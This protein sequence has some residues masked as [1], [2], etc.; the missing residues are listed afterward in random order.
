MRTTPRPRARL[1]LA[2]LLSL[3]AVALGSAL[4]AS[5][6]APEKGYAIATESPGATREAARVLDAGGNAFDAI[7]CAAL[8][9]GF[10][11]PASSGL[12]G[13]GFAMVYSA[14][15]QRPI[16]LDFREVAPAGLDEAA[17]AERPVPADQRGHTVG[18]P[19]E[20]SGLFELHQRYG[21]LRWKDVVGRAA[22]LA[23]QGFVLEPFT[24]QQVAEQQ[25]GPI[26]R[27]A[28]FR[29]AY[30]PQGAP[31]PA[32]TKLRATKLAATLRHL[33][34]QGKRGFYEGRV[35]R[36]MVDAVAAAGG[37]L[38]LTDLAAYRT[39]QRE[40]LRVSWEGK[41]L[42]TMPAP[43]AGGLLLAQTL[44]LF[45]KAE[46]AELAATPGKRLHLLAEA[47]RG[48]F[49]DRIRHLGDPAFTPVD[50]GKLLSA[51]R[52]QRRKAGLS[53]E[54]T[55]TQPRYG[56]E[57]QGTHQLV[58]ADAEGNWV[59]LTT[60][61]N[62]PFGAK[63]VAE[64]SG[65]ILNN[66]LEDF[67][68]AKSAAVFGI[69]D[70]PNR[71]RRGARPVS[72]MAPTLVLEDGVPTLALGGSGG[73]TIGPNVTQVALRILAEGASVEAAVAA[74]RFS[75]PPP[76]SGYTLSLEQALGE[77]Y[78]A[79]LRG[80]GELISTRDWKNAVQAVSRQGGTF[81]AAADPRKHGS[82][83]ARNS[84]AQ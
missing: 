69:T 76:Q 47:M 35:A 46:L 75:I 38:A 54:R 51:P 77:R 62:A 3:V 42:A 64:Q 27:S 39:V 65:I 58:A 9:S 8:V 14:R 11:N 24:S 32:G 70:N 31:A 25:N 57:E 6:A 26:A 2:L 21:K 84:A 50:M 40:P 23:A 10:T 1:E 49:A 44:A 30:L 17:L 71:P 43:S 29:G 12:G 37:A 83:L 78:E 82:A 55:H 66:E 79:D 81:A 7:V 5:G 28:S 68:P 74:P 80:R 19:G 48:A 61:V 13:G 36:D 16:V 34:D 18:V 22:R 67:T 20:V 45:S 41:E 60:T 63:I 15:E 73:L 53:A 56:L 59:A 4:P 33:A 52:L 72:S